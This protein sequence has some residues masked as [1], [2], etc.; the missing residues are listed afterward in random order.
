MYMKE[1]RI[2]ARL[3]VIAL[4][5]ICINSVVGLKCYHGV[6][7]EYFHSSVSFKIDTCQV[8]NFCIK[9]HR[10]DF[11]N[12]RSFIIKSCDD[13]GICADEGCT[14]GFVAAKFMGFK[15]GPLANI[16]DCCCKKM[17]CNSALFYFNHPIVP[18]SFAV[19]V[20]LYI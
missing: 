2:A 14:V 10:A 4:S 19:L 20:S 9:Y 18:V 11:R 12:Q 15:R 6:T 17:L 7:A 13:N 1:I 16:W 5:V 3:F 8:G